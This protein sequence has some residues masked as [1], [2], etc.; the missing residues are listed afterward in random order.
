MLAAR[1]GSVDSFGS[2]LA[3]HPR[4]V[5]RSKKPVI[6]LVPNGFIEIAPYAP[7]KETAPAPEAAFIVCLL[8]SRSAIL[9]DLQCGA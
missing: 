2:Y 4:K 5:V 6:V 1:L 9:L 7:P 8:R 3:R